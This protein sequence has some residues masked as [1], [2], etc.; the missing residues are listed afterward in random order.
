MARGV[1]VFL[2]SLFL[3]LAIQILLEDY[4]NILDKI[5]GPAEEDQ[6]GGMSTS[7]I[8]PKFIGSN[9]LSDEQVMDYT[10]QKHKQ[11][12]VAKVYVEAYLDM[13]RNKVQ[14]LDEGMTLRDVLRV[15]NYTQLDHR[16]L[17]DFMF[18]SDDAF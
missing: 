9:V 16:R 4:F 17:T 15:M 1:T 6:I 12:M 3:L 2:I 8:K 7:P 5:V 13:V 18:D 10:L 11:A 14:V